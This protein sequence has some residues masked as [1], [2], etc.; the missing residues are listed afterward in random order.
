[1][2]TSDALLPLFRDKTTCANSIREA[3]LA[4]PR[5]PKPKERREILNWFWA[6]ELPQWRGQSPPKWFHGFF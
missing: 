2:R 4:L 1:M 5:P 3:L 6:S